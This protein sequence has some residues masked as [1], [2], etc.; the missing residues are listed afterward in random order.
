M[1]RPKSAEG[2]GAPMRPRLT[3]RDAAGSA[4]RA[5]WCK[6]QAEGLIHPGE[7]L[8][9]FALRIKDPLSLGGRNASY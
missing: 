4:K 5:K 7:G 8:P 1:F 6:R 2:T 3:I 9:V